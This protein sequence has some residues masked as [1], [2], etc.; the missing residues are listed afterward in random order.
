MTDADA[1]FNHLKKELRDRIHTTDKKKRKEKRIAFWL[2]VT[3]VAFS[4]TIT[5]LLGFK[6]GQ[7]A[8][9][10]LS[11]GALILS[12]T[13][14]VLTAVDAFYNYRSLYIH[15][16]I[17]I[18]KLEGLV[19]RLD[20]LAAGRDP[21]ITREQMDCLLKEMDQVLA[22]DLQAWRRLRGDTGVDA[23]IQNG[24]VA[25]PHIPSP[26]TPSRETGPTSGPP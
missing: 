5:V 7:P 22:E 6:V 2:R 3:T 24:S 18:T 16:T 4:G 13:V 12:A 11:N 23:K 10:Y 20:Y 19:R 21:G 14:T 17:L 1:R 26:S 8:A 25:P 15:R 9:R